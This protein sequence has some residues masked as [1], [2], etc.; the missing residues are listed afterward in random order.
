MSARCIL[1]M[2]NGRGTNLRFPTPADVDIEVYAEHIA[3]EP[4]FNGATPGVIYNVADHA[5][6]VYDHLLA[7]TDDLLVAAYG[8]VHDNKEGAIKD[9]TTPLKNAIAEEI[10]AE[11]GVTAP[12]ILSCLERLEDRH[13]AAMHAALGLQW[14]PPAGIKEM[15]KAADLKLFV[16]EWRSLMRHADGT[17]FDH[18]DWGRYADIEQ[19][20]LPV[21]PRDFNASRWDYL[22]RCRV[23]LPLFAGRT[24]GLPITDLFP[25]LRSAA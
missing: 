10:E 13:D 20:P 11:C 25:S 7:T 5:C 3:K 21:M 4:R 19:L 12:A 6:R 16:T 9:W 24:G 17:V 23:A 14:P 8:L 2:A 15:V 18:P 1:T 22:S